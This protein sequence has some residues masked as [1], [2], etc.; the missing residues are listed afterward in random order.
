[1]GEKQ[2]RSKPPAPK[3]RKNNPMMK[4]FEEGAKSLLRL[5]MAANAV[6][7]DDLS[8]RLAEYGV[9][10]SPGGLANKISLGG[11]SAA[12]YIMCMELIHKEARQR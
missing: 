9:N 8:K 1:M 10:I 3:K 11:F 7:F 4:E 2:L 5:E 6:R 12:F